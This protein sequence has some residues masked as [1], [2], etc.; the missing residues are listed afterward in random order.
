[1]EFVSCKISQLIILTSVTPISIQVLN[2]F[3]QCNQLS[4]SI[5]K[6]LN[7]MDSI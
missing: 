7:S 1:M 4:R 6:K 2:V 3:K 5:A